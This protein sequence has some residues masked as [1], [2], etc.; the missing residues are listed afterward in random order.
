MAQLKI[1]GGIVNS[2]TKEEFEWDGVSKERVLADLTKLS[3]TVY[4][5]HW[6]Y[7]GDCGFEEANV[8]VGSKSFG[9][10]AAIAQLRKY[11]GGK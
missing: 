2:K 10:R 6:V 7:A 11:L 4:G 8:A 5:I 3:G 1:Y 9:G